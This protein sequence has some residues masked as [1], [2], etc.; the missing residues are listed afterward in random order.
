MQEG[1]NGKSTIAKHAWT[2]NHTIDDSVGPGKEKEGV[3]D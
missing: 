2:T 1:D 3:G